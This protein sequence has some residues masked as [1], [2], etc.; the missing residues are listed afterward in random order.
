L[1]EQGGLREIGFSALEGRAVFSSEAQSS[2]ED[3][4]QVIVHELSI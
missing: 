2:P 3:A 1:K 4:F